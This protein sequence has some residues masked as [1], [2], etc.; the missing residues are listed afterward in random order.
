LIEALAER[1]AGVCLET[2]GVRL[3]RV[4]LEKTYEGRPVMRGVGA[5]VVDLCRDRQG[6]AN[7][8]E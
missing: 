3:V 8:K 2:R 1:V 4:R 5:A 6:R 7:R